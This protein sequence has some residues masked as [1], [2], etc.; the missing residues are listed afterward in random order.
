MGHVDGR[1]PAAVVGADPDAAPP[2]ARS[3]EDNVFGA[4]AIEQ[5]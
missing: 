4:D 5:P 1:S 2:Y 3:A